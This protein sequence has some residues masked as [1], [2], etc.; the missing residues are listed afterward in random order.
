M[1]ASTGTTV[2]VF[3]LVEFVASGGIFALDRLRIEI[4]DAIT[5]N[6]VTG[7][8]A[9]VVVPPGSSMTIHLTADLPVGE[10]VALDA[11]I[12]AHSGMGLMTSAREDEMDSGV[13]AAGGD[14]FLS[15]IGEGHS[16]TIEK[17][18]EAPMRS[19]GRLNR[20]FA[21]SPPGND[22]VDLALYVDGVETAVVTDV[23]L[24]TAMTAVPFPMAAT[25]GRDQLV[26]IH[27]RKIAPNGRIRAQPCWGM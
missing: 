25:F 12:A 7:A 14:V 13:V 11:V 4:D 5:P 2:Q 20:I 8:G 1:P 17:A 16:P 23:A 18:N 26:S 15:F 9:V 10:D 24:T 21:C 3:D 6:V 27:A 22:T 19:A